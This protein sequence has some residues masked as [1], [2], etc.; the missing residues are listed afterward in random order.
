MPEGLRNA[1]PTFSRMTSVVLKNQLKRN[2]LAYVDDIVVKSVAGG[3]HLKD[4]AELSTASGNSKPEPGK[5]RV[6]SNKGKGLGLS[7]HF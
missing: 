4:L 7:G 1:G 2:I 5:M 3:D 6:R